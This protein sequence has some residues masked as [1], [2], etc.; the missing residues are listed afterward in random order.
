[1]GHV[2]VPQY[3]TVLINEVAI[4]SRVVGYFSAVKLSIGCRRSSARGAG[5]KCHLSCKKGGS[6][7]ARRGE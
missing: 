1:M 2:G 5:Y 6:A 7:I 4:D 3:I